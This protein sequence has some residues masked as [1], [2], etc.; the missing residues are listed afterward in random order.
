MLTKRHFLCYLPTELV[1]P[2]ENGNMQVVESK[3]NRVY[4]YEL[5][6]KD[7]PS[8]VENGERYTSYHKQVAIEWCED[9]SEDARTE[10]KIQSYFIIT[11]E[12]ETPTLHN[13]SYKDYTNLDF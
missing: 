4:Y 2:D 8:I 13:M 5:L 9:I 7:F 3:L 6:G 11:N 10:Y 1:I 12:L